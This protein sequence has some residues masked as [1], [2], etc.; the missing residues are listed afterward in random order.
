MAR[1]RPPHDEAT[2]DEVRALGDLSCRGASAALARR[3]IRVDRQTISK[4]RSGKYRVRAMPTLNKDERRVP[5]HRCDGCRGMIEIVPCRLCESLAMPDPL[6]AR[7][8]RAE[9]GK[10]LLA[11]GIA[12]KRLDGTLNSLAT[13]HTPARANRL[14]DVRRKHS[15][16]TSRDA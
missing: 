8:M 4:I 13:R 14:N 2:I 15:R 9:T 7:A 3:G 16:I 5:K 1:G 6:G 12:A 11:E 10:Q